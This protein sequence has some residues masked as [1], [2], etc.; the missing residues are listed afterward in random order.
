MPTYNKIAA[1]DSN[2]NFPPEIVDTLTDIFGPAWATQRYVPNGQNLNTFRVPGV[3]RISVDDIAGMFNLPPG[4]SYNAILENFQ[5]GN[6]VTSDWWMQRITQTGTDPRAWWRATKDYSGNWGTWQ[7]D[8][9]TAVLVADYISKDPTVVQAAADMAANN[10]NLLPKWKPNTVYTSGMQVVSP[11]GDI[12]T[13]SGNGTT[14]ATFS[15]TG[16]TAS[17][18]ATAIAANATAIGTKAGTATATSSASGLMSSADKAKLDA[19][20]SGATGSTLAMRYSDGR[21]GVTAP[22]GTTDAANKA[23]VDGK[24]WDGADITTGTI[25]DARIAKVT[26]ALDGLMLKADKTK[27][28][29][30]TVNS[31]PSTLAMRNS[32][33]RIDVADPGTDS[34]AATPRSYVDKV[35]DFRAN[36]GHPYEFIMG[37]IRNDGS[38]SGYFQLLD[39]ASNHR[40]VNIDSITTYSDKIRV[41][42][43]AMAANTTGMFIAV[44]D[45]TLAQQGIIMGTSVT[46]QY[47]EIRIS[48]VAKGLSDYVYFDGT[49]WVSYDGIFTGITYNGAGTLTINHDGIP[50]SSQYAVNLTGRGGN[51]LYSVSGGS[52]PTGSTQLKIEIRNI[53]TGATAGAA[54]TNMRVYISRGG[55]TR[56]INPQELTTV[57]YPNSNIWLFGAMAMD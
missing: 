57:L 45:E 26:A 52:A 56:D 7:E 49:N 18:N 20:A 40:T 46:P 24:V 5:T 34:A 3:H 12:I 35:V 11:T 19:A 21:L 10:A 27:L 33:G 14:G 47:T 8:K 1:T 31:T 25:S 15:M 37:V 16:W 29:A 48:Q 17:A 22:T 53:A 23:Y 4:I 28:D 9:Q 43:T 44:P 2:F 50:L 54:D 30:A 32:A 42:H 13:K 41:T 51:Y 39:E 36:D 55:G 6:A 38:A